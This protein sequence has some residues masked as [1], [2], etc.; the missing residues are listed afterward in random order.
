LI[1]FAVTLPYSTGQ[2]ILIGLGRSHYVHLCNLTAPIISL[3]LLLVLTVAQVDPYVLAVTTP[4]GMGFATLLTYRVAT[5][6]WGVG[7]T[8]TGRPWVAGSISLGEVMRK[9]ALPMLVATSVLPIAMQSARIIV[10]GTLSD[11]ELASYTMAATFYAPGYAVISASALALW[12][13]FQPGTARSGYIW[14]RLIAAM[15]LVGLAFG[16]IYFILSPLASEAVSGG[17]VGISPSLSCA[18]GALL[19]LMAVHQPSGMLLTS[20]SQLAYQARCGAAML[21]VSSVLGMV[22]VPLVGVAGP[23]CA[24]AIGVGLCQAAP[25]ILRAARV[26]RLPEVGRVE[27]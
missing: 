2:R 26:T 21:L 8:R 12:P 10:A 27:T 4:L 16:G 13:L 23:V 20:P 6:V 17:L 22:L 25:G 14:I 11:L 19:F 18:F 7:S 3:G 1:P 9:G 5:R 24:I 15:T